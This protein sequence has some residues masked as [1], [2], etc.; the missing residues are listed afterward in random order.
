VQAS[1][2]LPFWATLLGV[3]ASHPYPFWTK[4]S[5][6]VYNNGTLFEETCLTLSWPAKK[7]IQV[8]K[9]ERKYLL[10]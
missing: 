6:L 2:L 3:Q 9:P 7:V 10:V 5:L 1:H 8:M 4:A